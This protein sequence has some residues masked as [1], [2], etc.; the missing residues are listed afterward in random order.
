[1]DV[2]I[3][4]ENAE[5]KRPRRKQ[6]QRSLLATSYINF[7]VTTA[8]ILFLTATEDK[9]IFGFHT[10]VCATVRA[11]VCFVS[12]CPPVI[13]FHFILSVF[14]GS[15]INIRVLCMHCRGAHLQSSVVAIAAGLVQQ[16]CNDL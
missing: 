1:M 7:C 12:M 14:K 9:N 13:W 10:S 16:G 11:C 15:H 5:L 3:N 2:I 6:I 4:V 8:T